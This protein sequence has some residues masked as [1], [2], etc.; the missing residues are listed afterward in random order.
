M[1]EY[2]LGMSPAEVGA[3]FVAEVYWGWFPDRSGCPPIFM[4]T[5]VITFFFA[6]GSAF[7]RNL[8]VMCSLRFS[9]GCC[10]RGKIAVDLL[11]FSDLCVAP[12]RHLRFLAFRSV[13]DSRDCLGDPVSQSRQKLAVFV[14]KVLPE[15]FDQ[16]YWLECCAPHFVDL[17]VA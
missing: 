11:M 12:V 3:G 1:C 6:V 4:G 7:E 17:P 13:S 9:C 8:R 14:A 5:L 16:G 10:A 15:S 2:E